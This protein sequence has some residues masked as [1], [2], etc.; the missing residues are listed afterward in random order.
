MAANPRTDKFNPEDFKQPDPFFEAIGEAREYY[1]KNRAKVLGIAGAVV[2]ALVLV[3]AVSGW[4]V[5]QR[6]GA[7]TDFARAV[8]NLEFD[9][10]SA[11]EANLKSLSERSNTGAYSS[12]AALYQGNLA[13]DAGRFDE[14]AA[15]YDKFLADAPAEYLRQVGLMGKAAAMEKGGK[16][17]E[18]ASALD[19][20]AAI[21]GPYRKAALSDRARLAEKAGDKA[22][23]RT[24]LQRL[25][26]LEGSS[27]DSAALE[28][29]IEALK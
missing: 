11:A 9:S 7:A 22:T 12:L 28:R 25:L 4:M 10:P 14:A 8:G 27:G 23:A 15:A 2:T 17:G 13:L 16:I 1:D 5:S 29:R 3:T 18:A 20:A 19:A 24:S 21:E 6:Q 26:E